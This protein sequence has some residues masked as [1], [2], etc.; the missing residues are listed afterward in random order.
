M[1]KD[2]EKKYKLILFVSTYI[3]ESII[4]FRFTKTNNRNNLDNGWYIRKRPHFKYCMSQSNFPFINVLRNVYSKFVYKIN[5]SQ[6]LPGRERVKEDP[7]LWVLVLDKEKKKNLKS[8]PWQKQVYWR[9][10]RKNRNKQLKGEVGQTK[11]GTGKETEVQ[12]FSR[13]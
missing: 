6:G 13:H 12:E 5:M 9:K 4:F 3:D 2:T 11:R 10:N 1:V 7:P 8:Y